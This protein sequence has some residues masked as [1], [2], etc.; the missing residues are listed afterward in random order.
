MADVAAASGTPQRDFQFFVDI[1]DAFKAANAS[2]ADGNLQH[3]KIVYFLEGMTMFLRIF[4]AFN[5]PLLSE[6]VKKDV[7]GNISVSYNRLSQSR[8]QSYRDRLKFKLTD[9]FTK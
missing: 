9:A 7:L 4:D 6:G 2:A 5:N 8:H 1:I 3:I